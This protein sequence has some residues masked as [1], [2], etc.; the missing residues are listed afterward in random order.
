M[1]SAKIFTPR[2]LF[3]FNNINLDPL[4][5]TYDVG[6]YLSYM[7]T[8]PD[9]NYTLHSPDGTQ[10]GYIMGKAEGPRHLSEE[11]AKKVMKWHGHVTAVTVAPEFRRLGVATLLMDLLEITTE[12]NYEGSF[13]DLFVRAS[14]ANAITMYEK[15][16]YK[17]YRKVLAYYQDEGS[18]QEDGL[19]MRKS[20]PLDPKK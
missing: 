5:A 18:K 10:M 20:T 12:L 3:E 15:L 2:H 8:W 14:N 17:V 19:D 16:G 13:V 4:T 11:D 1:T 9:Y 7:A 6:Y